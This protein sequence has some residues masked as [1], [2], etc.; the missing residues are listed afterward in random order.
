MFKVKTNRAHIYR[1]DTNFFVLAV[2]LVTVV[3]LAA[4]RN[5]GGQSLMVTGIWARPGLADGNSAIYFVIDNPTSADDSLLSV[6]SDVAEAVEMHMTMMKNGNM[7][8]VPQ[9]EV[10]VPVGQTEFKPGGL[11]VMLIG[12]KQDLNPGD[13]F[14][15]TLRFRSAG[16]KS[17]EVTVGEP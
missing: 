3:L 11:H 2:F 9:K 4:C 1:R 10:P 17:L 5:A 6:S 14:S 7:Q 16:E 15:V 12:L 8:M 13:T